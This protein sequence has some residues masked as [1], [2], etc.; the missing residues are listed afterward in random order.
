MIIDGVVSE[1]N[2]GIGIDRFE[3]KVARVVMGRVGFLRHERAR[4]SSLCFED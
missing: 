1:V 2:E 4:N 3:R